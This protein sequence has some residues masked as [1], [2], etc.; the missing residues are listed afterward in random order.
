MTTQT[1]IAEVLHL[2]RELQTSGCRTD[3]GRVE[4]LI[5]DDYTEIGASGR[6]W[7]RA[8]IITMLQDETADDDEIQVSELTG[9]WITEDL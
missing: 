2:E 7:D 3:P 4:E 1:Q 9:R 8:S 6:L 5:A